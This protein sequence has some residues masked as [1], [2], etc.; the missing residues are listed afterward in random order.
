MCD[1]SGIF[2]EQFRVGIVYCISRV[3][4]GLLFGVYGLQD[5]S[6][7]AST[8]RMPV[9]A[10]CEP[11]MITASI[12]LGLKRP[13]TLDTYDIFW[14]FVIFYVYGESSNVA[15]F[16]HAENTYSHEEKKM[17]K[18]ISAFPIFKFFCHY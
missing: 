3:I 13:L 6:K 17:E 12:L 10:Y 11:G 1:I 18:H 9:I 2:W 5:E 14:Y 7:Q 4:N 15:V 16:R 8:S